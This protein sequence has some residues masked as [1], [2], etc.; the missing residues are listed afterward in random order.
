MD[1]RK[2]IVFSIDGGNFDILQPLIEKGEVPNIESIIKGG[3]SSHLVSVVP[4]ITAPAWASFM[5]GVNPG[6]HRVFDFVS[7]IHNNAKEGSALNSTHIRS[8]T[9]WQIMS[10]NQREMIIVGVPFTYPAPEINGSMVSLSMSNLIDTYPKE[11]KKVI[12][13][14]IG[15]EYD[16][17]KP[18]DTFGELPK[19]DV[20]DE[21]IR[22]NEYLTEKI[23]QTTLNLLQQKKWDFLM[24][25]FMATDTN[26]H[27]FWHC[28]DESHPSYD[29]RLA[30]K[31]H[32]VIN[33][34]YRQVDAAIGEIL[35]VAGKDANVFV[36]SDHGFSPIY[37]FFYVNNWLEKHGLLKTKRSRY[38]WKPAKPSLFKFLS[39]AGLEKLGDIL[40]DA[41]RNIGIP[42]MKRVPK[43]VAEIID[44]K[45]TKA[46]ASPF[47]I[48]INLAGRE[49]FGIVGK[50]K[51]YDGVRESIKSK[52]FDLMDS[53]DIGQLVDRVYFR[54]EVYS[55]PFVDD[56]AD[57]FFSFSRPYFLQSSDVTKDCLFENLSKKHFATANHRYSPEGIFF[58][59]GMDIHKKV[60][61]NNPSILDI[62]P[63][64][65]YLMGISIPQEMDG[66]MLE[67]IIKPSYLR[68]RPPVYAKEEIATRS[69]KRESL[70]T[71][72]EV[73]LKD[74][75][76][77]LGY[78]G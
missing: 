15:F 35:K 65:L 28:I 22:R 27:Y 56:A 76:R 58:A 66:K 18:V 9:I 38:A 11:L 67:K 48:N 46:Y 17:C 43:S 3:V 69:D 71:E 74:H 24:T 26:Q 33:E 25:H 63:T 42:I 49:P 16:R 29:R 57:I 23:K 61:L 30:L 4:P 31:Y 52:L 13:D 34:T 72:E 1:N 21:I 37:K 62:A 73:A 75:L 54:E 5:T 77:R 41:L 59:S 53:G 6:K 45:K 44:W 40:P 47:G 19:E 51:E 68:A 55:G 50:E 70:T 10:E 39:K 12:I 64:I 14:E 78:L 8:K 36:V 7:D 20:L 2:M 60:R 32:D